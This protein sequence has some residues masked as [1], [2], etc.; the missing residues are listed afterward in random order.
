MSVRVAR[1]RRPNAVEC[2]RLSSAKPRA[3]VG[4]SIAAKSCAGAAYRRQR[5]PC[6]LPDFS[7]LQIQSGVYRGLGGSNRGSFDPPGLGAWGDRTGRSCSI[8]PGGRTSK[9]REHR[10]ERGLLVGSPIKKSI[11]AVGHY[12]NPRTSA[13]TD[14]ALPLRNP[15]RAVTCHMHSKHTPALTL[16]LPAPPF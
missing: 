8:P 12:S 4:A 15:A 10:R 6:A 5:R 13:V 9:G 16:S 14:S 3:D 2:G 11:A 7:P 1:G